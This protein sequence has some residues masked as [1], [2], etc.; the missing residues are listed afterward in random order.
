MEHIHIFRADWNYKEISELELQSIRIDENGIFQ[1]QTNKKAFKILQ[2]FKG[3]KNFYHKKAKAVFSIKELSTETLMLYN[4]G[5]NMVYPARLNGDDDGYAYL[6][7]AYGEIC[8]SCNNIPKGEQIKPLTLAKEPKLSKKYIWGSFHG[9]SGCLF[10]DKS[11]Y[12][13]LMDKWA[14]KSIDLLIGSKQ[15]VSDNFV[16]IDIPISNSP[17]CFGESNFG[18]TFKLDGS[19]QISDSKIICEE[20]RRSLHTNQ[21]LDYFPSFEIQQKFDIVFTQEWFGWYRR[22]VINKDFAKWLN[23]NKFITY[24]SDYLVP[25]KKF[26][27]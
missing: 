1:I 22:L 24:D 21:L 14:L 8:N 7:Y 20:C 9:V 19:G 12:K 4:K 16:Q 25:I 5:P 6:R 3:A 26:C 27:K 11:R 15:K 23:E 10:T 17:L 13:L 2:K 18:N